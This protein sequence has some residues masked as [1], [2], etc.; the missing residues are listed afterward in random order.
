MNTDKDGFQFSVE[1]AL[2]LVD[3][4]KSVVMIPSFEELAGY[5]LPTTSSMFGVPGAFLYLGDS[6]LPLPCFFQHGIEPE[7]TERIQKACA[8]MFA[9]LSASTRR[10]S[11]LALLPDS[12]TESAHI[13]G[14]DGRVF[15]ISKLA[16]LVDVYARRLQCQERLTTQIADA[17]VEHGGA[18][19][20][21]VIIDAAHMCMRMRGVSKQNSSMITSEVRGIL[22]HDKEA[23]AEALNLIG[24]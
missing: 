22:Y 17:L 19:G 24:G 10:I 1:E 16:R 3:L 20:A 11:P 7:E 15:G 18:Q 6:R 5:V 14:K 8:E 21:I 13:P 9:G 12:S 23:R 4:A 2:R